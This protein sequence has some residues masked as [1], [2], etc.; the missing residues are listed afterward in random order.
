MASPFYKTGQSASPLFTHIPGHLDKKQNSDK[1]LAPDTKFVKGASKNISSKKFGSGVGK[2]TK[3]KTNNTSSKTGETVR[4]APIVVGS[5]E[6]FLGEG[7]GGYLQNKPM[8]NPTGAPEGSDSFY[9]GNKKGGYL[10]PSPQTPGSKST[11]SKTS[12]TNTNYSKNPGKYLTFN[13]K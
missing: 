11:N 10:A 5:D 3:N 12:S 8:T 4:A 2:S 13:K 1:P 9:T 6:Y 7:K